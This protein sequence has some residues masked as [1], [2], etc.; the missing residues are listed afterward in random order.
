MNTYLL[1]ACVSLVITLI[2]FSRLLTRIRKERDDLFNTHHRLT[3]RIQEAHHWLANIPQADL[4]TDY[5]LAHAGLKHDHPV[6]GISELREKILL[7]GSVNEATQKVLRS[8]EAAGRTAKQ[9]LELYKQLEGTDHPELG[10]SGE[11][12]EV[13]IKSRW[14]ISHSH[15]RA[16]SFREAGIRALTKE[17]LGTELPGGYAMKI[18][19]LNTGN[20]LETNHT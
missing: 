17:G 13:E 5:L 16:G 15:I 4:L 3:A 20:Y 7:L 19:S 6:L 9:T 10:G 12:Y 14:M 11:V 2:A 18:T 8:C 1:I